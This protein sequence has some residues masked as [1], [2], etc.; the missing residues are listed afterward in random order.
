M[1]VKNLDVV[2]DSLKPL[3]REYLERQGTTFT[4]SH[5]QCPNRIAHRNNDD[6]PSASFYPNIENFHCFSC[7]QNGDI[8]TAA[9]LLEGY[10][11]EGNDFIETAVAL[12]KQFDIP[13]EIEEDQYDKQQKRLREML[14]L[15]RD[16]SHKTYKVTEEIKQ[17][18]IKRNLVEIENSIKFGYCN[19]EKLTNFLFSKG[20]TEQDLKDAG[21]FKELINQRLLIPIYDEGNRLISFCSRQIREDDS[22]RYY[23]AS[24]SLLYKKQEVL[25]NFNLAKKSE[26]I[27]IVEGNLDCLTMVKNGITNVVALSGD[28]ISEK[29]VR[30]LVKYGIKKIILCLDNDQAGKE[31]TRK[32]IDV[33]SPISEIITHVVELSEAKDPDEFINKFGIEKFK[34]LTE[35]DAFEYKLRKYSSSNLDK[36]LKEDLI[37]FISNEQSFIEKENMCK[38]LA[39]VASVK[40]ETVLQE[41]ERIEKVKSGDYGVTTSDIV[42]E[43]DSF[44]KEI[45]LFENWSQSRGKLLGLNLMFP[46]M[47]EKLDGLQNKLYIIGAEENTGKTALIVSMCLNL[48]ESNP[49]KI[50][51]LY[52]SL[53]D[54]AR[55]IISRMLANKT[56]LEINSISNP[57]WKI[58]NNPTLDESTKNAKMK[59]RDDG[60]NYIRSLS[61]SISVKDEKT[62]RSMEDMDRLI[63]V[64]QHLIDNKQL[65]VIVDSLHCI[66][67]TAKRETRDIMMYISDK[68][69]E[70]TTKFDVPVIAI[71]ELRKLQHPGMKPTNDDLKEVSDLKYDADATILLYNELHSR[72]ESER[73][74]VGSNGMVYPVVELIFYK[75]KTSGFKGT[76]FY[77]FYTDTS[78]FEECSIDEHRQYWSKI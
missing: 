64:Y 34:Q 41:I 57:T 78:K 37:K 46:I 65:V 39:K 45:F 7:N 10:A 6:K 77:K 59:Q 72:R 61:D 54:N 25:Y 13:A 49:N 33:L 27:F 19:Y 14:E 1:K 60:L 5:F 55:T 70:W 74:F 67:T 76:L 8:F 44:N 47:T 29:Q 22:Q 58:I 73:T 50:Y 62:V 69:K 48:V 75:N 28:A 12:A 32:V 4:H 66:N 36:N 71:S 53:D 56:N 31:A 11:L 63:K 2:V 26:W 3:L 9:N 24:T 30:L 23:N 35:I 20:Y 15:I 42:N 16:V 51:V 21:I 17:Y 43:K 40:T 18:V 68:L 52:F 38:R